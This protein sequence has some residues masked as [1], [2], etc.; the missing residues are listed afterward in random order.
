MSRL[1]CKQPFYIAVLLL[2]IVC[3]RSFGLEAV[4]QVMFK[5]AVKHKRI[6]V[7]KCSRLLLILSWLHSCI[8]SYL[9]FYCTLLQSRWWWPMIILLMARQQKMSSKKSTMK[10]KTL[11]KEIACQQHISL[12]DW[13]KRE[14]VF[15]SLLLS[16]SSYFKSYCSLNYAKLYYHGSF[17]HIYQANRCQ[18]RHCSWLSIGIPYVQ[19]SIIVVIHWRVSG[20]SV[21]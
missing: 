6:N 10:W 9:S 12:F 11:K 15:S 19:D 5:L 14:C 7:T 8:E 3:Y 18:K 1:K 2:C 17:Q 20:I 4:N 13:Y 16:L 21:F